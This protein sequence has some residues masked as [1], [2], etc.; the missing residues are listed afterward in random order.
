[1]KGSTLGSDQLSYSQLPVLQS[2]LGP[3]ISVLNTE[4]LNG[5]CQAKAAKTCLYVNWIPQTM[6]QFCYLKLYLGIETVSGCLFL[7]DGKN[8]QGL[9]LEKNW[10]VIRFAGLLSSCPYYWSVRNRE[11]STR[12]ELT[13]L[14]YWIGLV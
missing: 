9:R 8:G 1:M 7:Q 2:P 5:L 13:V 6:V 4:S 11:V 10:P 12:Q 14:D 3:R